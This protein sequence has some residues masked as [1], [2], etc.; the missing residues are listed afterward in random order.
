MLSV[1]SGA[2]AT[3]V[4]I[5]V[6]P[7]PLASWYNTVQGPFASLMITVTVAAVAP[8]VLVP[9]PPITAV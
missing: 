7:L 5:L 6:N 4:T 3:S 9:P 1:C 2:A 8:Q